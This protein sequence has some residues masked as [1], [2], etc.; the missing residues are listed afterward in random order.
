MVLITN[1]ITDPEELKPE[2]DQLQVAIVLK[3]FDSSSQYK[4]RPL[5]YYF[6]VSV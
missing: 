5:D 6:R 2:K 1:V 3:T 4:N